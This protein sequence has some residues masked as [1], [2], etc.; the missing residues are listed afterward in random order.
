MKPRQR[1]LQHFSNYYEKIILLMQAD[2]H[3]ISSCY[4]STASERY[5]FVA[6]KHSITIWFR[7][8]KEE[9]ILPKRVPKSYE[10][11]YTLVHIFQ[12]KKNIKVTFQLSFFFPTEKLPSDSIF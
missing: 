12:F 11:L 5:T 10:I 7:H 8:T 3:R 2:V 6:V 9:H 4:Q 1:V